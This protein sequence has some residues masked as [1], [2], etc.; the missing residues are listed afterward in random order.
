VDFQHIVAVIGTLLTIYGYI[1]YFQGML[2]GELKPHGFSWFIWAMLTATGFAA[3]IW[4]GGGWGA[5]IMGATA[6]ACLTISL[7]SIRYG[8][9]GITRSDWVAFIIGLSAIPLWMI[10]DSP[11]ASVVILAMAD[12][13]G[14]W[15]SI[16]KTWARPYQEGALVFVVAVAKNILALMAM[17]DLNWVTSFYPFALIFINAAFVA[18][19]LLRRRSVKA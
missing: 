1:A 2:R 4:G 6:L 11:A 19:I 12:A 10:T 3:Q 18:M 16:R 8:E 17:D 13:I 7:L 5:A 9:R 14:Y 15:P